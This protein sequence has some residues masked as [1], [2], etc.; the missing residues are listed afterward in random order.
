MHLLALSD[1]VVPYVYS[2]SVKESYKDVQLIV[3]CG[4]LPKDYLEYVVSLLDVPLVYVPGNHDLDAYA[5]PGGASVDGRVFRAA[6]L[7]V[8][9]LGGS[10][11]YKREGRHQYTEAEMRTRALWLGLRL[12]LRRLAGRGR[13]DML[14]THAPARA[15]HDAPDHTHRGFQAFR[16]LLWAVRPRLM[17]HGHVHIAPNLDRRESELYGVRILNVYPVLKVEL[18]T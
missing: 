10:R 16:G 8:A 12:V 9:G 2:P 1:R 7:T 17:L 14:V 18:Q 6:G 11:R 3:G 13:L 4:D 15:I 5:V